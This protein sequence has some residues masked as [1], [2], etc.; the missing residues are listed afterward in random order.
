MSGLRVLVPTSRSWY[1]IVSAGAILD[2]EN[3][4]AESA[5]VDFVDVPPL[6]RRARI[7]AAVSERRPRRIALSGDYDLCFLAVFQPEDVRALAFLE[8]LRRR[9][10]RVVVYVFDAWAGS[11]A[12]LRRHR[13]LWRLCDQVFVSFP[14]AVDAWRPELRCPVDYLPQ[15]IDPARFHPEPNRPIHVLSVGRRLESVH[16]HLVDIASR[17][18][19]WYQFSESRAPVAIDLEDSQLLLA[20]LCRSARI[21][22]CWPLE[23]THAESRRVG[24]TPA[25]GSPITARWFEAAASGSIVM[26]SKPASPEFDRLFPDKA[27]VRELPRASESQLELAVLEALADDG[28]LHSRGAL[29]QHV[30]K[31]HCWQVRCAEILATTEERAHRP[32]FAR[33]GGAR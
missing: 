26:G 10:R 20:R 14:A 5:V 19:L 21:Q 16:R 25:D 1:R 6:G 30:L 12:S 4:M 17:H 18:G 28:E 3:A 13:E 29:A 33:V 15:A 22:I 2:F 11:A 23:L 7:R 27:F 9:C 32:T 31:H 24:Y 8:G